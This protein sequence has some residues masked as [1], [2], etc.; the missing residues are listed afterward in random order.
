MKGNVAEAEQLAIAPDGKPENISNAK[1]EE[2]VQD[3]V[4][5]LNMAPAGAEKI[6]GEVTEPLN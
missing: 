6:D 5:K 2:S 3:N 1:I 4:V